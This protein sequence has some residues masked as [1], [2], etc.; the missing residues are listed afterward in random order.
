MR[1]VLALALLAGLSGGTAYGQGDPGRG[2]YLVAAGG[3]IGCHTEDT[4]D[5]AP[6]AGGRA[7]ETPFGTFYGPNI[8]PDPQAGIGRWQESDFINAMRRGLRPDGA[9]YFP[10]FPYT[11]FTGIMD[12][13]LADLWAYLKTLPPSSRASRPH[14]LRFPFGLRILMGPWK[15][16]FFKEGPFRTDSARAG[17]VDRGAY[18]VRALAHCDECHTPRNFLG[19]LQRDRHLAGV[20]GGDGKGVPNI[21]PTRLGKWSDEELREVLSSGIAPDFDSVN[22]TMSEV[23]E[24]TTSKLTPGDLD[25]VIAYLRTLVPLPEPARK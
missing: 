22:K 11:S 24:N 25:A 1:W 13:D 5:A 23:V 20:P 7:L 14:E 19:V 4:K 16:L 10:A 3:C 8:T 18:L 12:A 21:T 6:F 17:D 15:W 2:E 9:H